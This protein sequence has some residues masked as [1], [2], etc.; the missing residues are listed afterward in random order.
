MAYIGFY[1]IML[2]LVAAGGAITRGDSLAT[3]IAMTAAGAALMWLYREEDG[4]GGEEGKDAERTGSE[5]QAP[6]LRRPVPDQVPAE[7]VGS[8][9]DALLPCADRGCLP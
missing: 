8:G 9:K 1:L 7:G 2:G 5:G 3:A 6:C 4:D